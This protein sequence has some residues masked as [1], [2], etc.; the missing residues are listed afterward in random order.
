MPFTMLERIT[1]CEVNKG[2]HSTINF[3]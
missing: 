1:Q 2:K 3:L